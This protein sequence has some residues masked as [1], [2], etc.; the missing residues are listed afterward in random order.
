[1]SKSQIKICCVYKLTNLENGRMYV[2]GTTHYFRRR[3][4]HL[5]ELRHNLHVSK[6]MQ[7]DFNDIGEPYFFFTI[8]ERTDMEHLVEKEQYWLDK[9]H[10]E[11]NTSR[12]A[13]KPDERIVLSEKAQ[14]SRSES[15]KRLWENPEYRAKCS[16]PRN[17]K[18]GIPN[19]KGAKL[20]DETK[21]KIRQANLGSKNPHYGKPRSQGF[22]AKVRKIYPGVVSPDG[23]IF[24]CIVGLNEFC[25][26]HGLDSGQMSRLMSGKVR[27]YK[28]WK[29]YLSI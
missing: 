15:V 12:F 20:S 14:L 4:Q 16:I 2:G 7:S 22:L 6:L 17:W 13:E 9:L 23:E 18:N 25:R 28:G 8:I 10:P 19:R 1:M 11:Y 5:H 21:E 29:I 27:A 24:L 26:E 3:R